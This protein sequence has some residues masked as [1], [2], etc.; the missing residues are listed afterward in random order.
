M[1]GGTTA[2]RAVQ[3]EARPEPVQID[4]SRTALIVVDMQNVFAGRG[5]TPG[6][7]GPTITENLIERNRR[8]TEIAR[9]A[10]IKLIYLA[11]MKDPARKSKSLISGV[12]DTK[13]V[14]CKS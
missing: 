6:R 11:M 13:I 3:I 1:S 5:E 7:V 8:L 4:L 9:K 10:T 12:G 14:D 2:E